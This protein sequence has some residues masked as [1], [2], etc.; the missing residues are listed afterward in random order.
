MP[1]L[2]MGK[3]PSCDPYALLFDMR[4]GLIGVLATKRQVSLQLGGWGV[5]FEGYGKMV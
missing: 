5:F 3:F 1:R 4:V 2:K